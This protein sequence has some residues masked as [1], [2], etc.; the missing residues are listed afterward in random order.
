MKF[1]SQ[2]GF[3]DESRNYR[4]PLTDDRALHDVPLLEVAGLP[5]LLVAGV[6][7]GYRHLPLTFKL[8]LFEL[9]QLFS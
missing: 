9:V 5:R 6:H 8:S 2:I 4:M 1:L 7:G 3:Q